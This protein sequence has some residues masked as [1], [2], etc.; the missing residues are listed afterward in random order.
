MMIRPRSYTTEDGG[1]WLDW[2]YPAFDEGLLAIST[3]KHI[4]LDG[5]GIVHSIALE[6][7]AAGNG[8]FPR[9][10]ALNGWTTPNKHIEGAD[11]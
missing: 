3:D 8:N 1:K 5:A 7:P 11:A 9:W 2:V 10:D 6:N 4:V